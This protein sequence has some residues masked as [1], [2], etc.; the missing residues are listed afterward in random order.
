[1]IIYLLC[2]ALLLVGLYG[3]LVKR[4]MVRIIIASGIMGYASNLLLVLF[5]YKRGGLFPILEKGRAVGDRIMVDPLPQALVLTSIV[6]ELGITAMLVALAIRL[7]EKN[8]TFD[9][10]KTKRLSG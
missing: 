1:V 10:T 9:I 8:K 7:F 3:L 6:I 2:F 5:A 4:D